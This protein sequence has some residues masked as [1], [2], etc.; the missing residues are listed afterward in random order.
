MAKNLPPDLHKQL[1]RLPNWT[2]KEF[3]KIVK[4]LTP[5]QR[6]LIDSEISKASVRFR[7]SLFRLV[8]GGRRRS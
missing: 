7:R 5:E 6:N 3:Q 1:N 2:E 4:R 8:P